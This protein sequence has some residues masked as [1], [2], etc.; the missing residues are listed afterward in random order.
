MKRLLSLLVILYSILP[1]WVYAQEATPHTLLNF[2][3]INGTSGDTDITEWLLNSE[4]H[5]VFYFY[6]EDSIMLMANTSFNSDSQSYGPTTKTLES[7]Y[8]VSEEGYETEV[9]YFDWS[10]INSYDDE[11]GI[12]KIKAIFTTK[13]DAIYLTLYILPNDFELIVYNG[14]T[15][16]DPDL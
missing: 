1:G 8:G 13:P 16:G 9:W 3:I 15:E 10:Y 11:T 14:V 6:E 7:E 2:R 12:A 4:M 5:T